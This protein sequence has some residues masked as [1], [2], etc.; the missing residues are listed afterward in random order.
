M[1]EFIAELAIL[2]I[3]GLFEIPWRGWVFAVLPAFAFVGLVVL[4]SR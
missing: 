1:A 3:E 2:L 4:F